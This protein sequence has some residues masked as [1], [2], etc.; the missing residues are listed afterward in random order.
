MQWYGS[1]EDMAWLSRIAIGWLKD[2]V[3]VE[4]VNR[5]LE[6]RGF[7][8]SSSYMGGKGIVWTFETEYDRDGFINNEFFWRD[9]F[10][11]MSTWNEGIG[12][13]TSLKWIDV[14]GVPLNCWSPSFF[15]KLRNRVGELVWIDE[16]T[17]NR[18]RFDK[19][20]IMVLGAQNK[21][22]SSEV[23][24]Q[25][26]KSNMTVRLVESSDLVSNRWVYELLGLK[27]GALSKE[28]TQIQEQKEI[29]GLREIGSPIIGKSPRNR[30]SRHSLTREQEEKV[31]SISYSKANQKVVGGKS[32][33][34]D[35][36]KGRI[37]EAQGVNGKESSGE[38]HSS[39]DSGPEDRAFLGPKLVKG[40]YSKPRQVGSISKNMREVNTE[41]NTDS[42]SASWGQVGSDE[43]NMGHEKWP[44]KQLCAHK[45]DGNLKEKHLSGVAMENEGRNEKGIKICVDLRDKGLESNFEQY[46]EEYTGAVGSFDATQDDASHERLGNGE[47]EGRTE[48]LAEGG[49]GE[50][51][52]FK[53]K[54][55]SRGS[56]SNI[57]THPMITRKSKANTPNDHL[58]NT[59]KIK[60]GC[61]RRVVW[62]ME[63]E[64]AK[65]IEKGVELGIT[66]HEKCQNSSGNMSNTDKLDP[67]SDN[68]WNLEEEVSKIIETGTA[69]GFDFHGNETEITEIVIAKERED[70]LSFTVPWVMGGDFNTVLLEKERRGG[71]FNKWSARAFNSFILHAKV[72]DTPLRG[73]EFTWSNNREAGSWARLDRFLV[74]PEIFLWFPDLV[75]RGI[76]RS[77]SDH[78][79]IILGSSKQSWGPSPFQIF[80]GWMED[81]SLTA[82]IKRNWLGNDT[83]LFI[84]PKEEYLL[85]AR[86]T[87]RC[88]E[89][90][91]ELKLNFKKSCVVRVGR[92][93]DREVEWATIF[94][95]AKGSLP[96]LYLGLP[97]GGRPSSKIFW[98]DL[99]RRV[100]GR[101]APWKKIFLNKGAKW[102][103][104]FG[105]EEAPLWKRVIGAKYGVSNDLLRW[106][107]NCGNSRSDM[108]KAVGSLFQQ[109]TLTARVLE[110]G[111]RVVVGR[112][113]K[114]RLWEDV[115]VEG[116]PLR[117]A[118]PRIYILAVK[119]SGC[120]RDFWIKE[121][122]MGKWA[123]ALEKKSF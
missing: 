18:G 7:A 92:E 75:Q 86:R 24:V 118:F 117:T 28:V 104:R 112:G 107:W 88:F 43:N 27:A 57:K 73:M 105:S 108:V 1:V 91:S 25:V 47:Q 41:L 76:P 94:R 85:N 89:M 96:I 67:K 119:K 20:R 59:S 60:K 79:A 71:V 70:E 99:V 116:T 17:R 35:K 62:N 15:R 9:H 26:G 65:A 103:W 121:G 64:I 56:D 46:R 53:K 98:A 87:L 81:Q 80:N 100:E 58:E 37:G 61:Q 39:S 52:T 51:E 106:D 42:D 97:L 54:D 34:L 16:E 114:A 40:D 5:K 69:L 38:N 21:N 63:V 45:G 115:L 84:Q 109:G 102:A 113:D 66:V 33:W 101:L 50:V 120:V 82:Q 44:E 23:K 32:G 111:L 55:R 13:S 19:G 93:G 90:A 22:I 30:E 2:F 48:H 4:G 74:S 29:I 3:N 36:G 78:K 11:S 14:Y 68:R 123:G 77:I 83:M 10:V 122:M 49:M 12:V 31:P 6:S 8:F 72:I 95:S 110:E